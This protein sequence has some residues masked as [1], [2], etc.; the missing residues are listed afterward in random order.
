MNVA[1]TPPTCFILFSFV[2]FNPL[3]NHNLYL[4]TKFGKIR[5]KKI[6]TKKHEKSEIIPAKKEKV[7]HALKARGWDSFCSSG[8][9][10]ESKSAPDHRIRT[11][12][13]MWKRETPPT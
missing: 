5:E 13:E 1:L 6:L 9:V 8:Q 11:R 12:L 2:L 7:V 3:F 4:D 10:D